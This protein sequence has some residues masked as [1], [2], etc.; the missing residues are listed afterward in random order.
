MTVTKT[1]ELKTYT[2]EEVGQ[3]IANVRFKERVVSVML[4][5]I[6]R[7]IASGDP[8]EY[9]DVLKSVLSA[10]M[11]KPAEPSEPEKKPDEVP[12]EG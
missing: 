6:Q 11:P 12:V 9:T 5:A 1:T 8:Q 2:E 7:S 3:M 4:T 10:Q